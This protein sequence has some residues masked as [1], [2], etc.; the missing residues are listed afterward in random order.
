MLKSIKARLT[1]AILLIA[2]LLDLQLYLHRYHQPTE[3]LGEY[4][5]KRLE[6]YPCGQSTI[7]ATGKCTNS[8]AT[9]SSPPPTESH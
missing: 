5:Q 2:G 4:L 1:F 9:R 6:K 7:T 3:M 8:A